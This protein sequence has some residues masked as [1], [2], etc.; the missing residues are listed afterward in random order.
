MRVVIQSAVLIGGLGEVGLS[1][2]SGDDEGVLEVLHTKFRPK[3]KQA[4]RSFTVLISFHLDEGQC[5]SVHVLQADV[6]I[7]ED[8][9]LEGGGAVEH[10]DGLVG[11]HLGA[12]TVRQTGRGLV[13]T[14]AAPGLLLDGLV[15]EHE[16]LSNGLARN[17]LIT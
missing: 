3:L 16:K 9:V 4:L 13:D 2:F 7:L 15:R 5:G 11:D 10:G 6:A 8:L 17:S 14:H 1:L 12:A